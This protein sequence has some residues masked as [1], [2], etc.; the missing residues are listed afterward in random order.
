MS[1]FSRKKLPIIIFLITCFNIVIVPVVYAATGKLEPRHTYAL[2]G[3]GIITLGLVIYLF[4]VV[5]RPD[6]Y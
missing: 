5:F 6:R 1:Y 4:D 3:L 2:A